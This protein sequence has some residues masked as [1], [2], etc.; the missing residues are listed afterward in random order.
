MRAGYPCIGTSQY[1][2]TGVDSGNGIQKPASPI[3]MIIVVLPLR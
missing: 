3:L 2:L 1:N